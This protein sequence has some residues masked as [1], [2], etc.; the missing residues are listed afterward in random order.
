MTTQSEALEQILAIARHHQ[1]TPEDISAAFARHETPAQNQTSLLSRVFSL[2]G[3]TFLFAGLSVFIALN[4][5]VMNTW[6][7]IIITL[8]SGLAVFILALIA[9][10]DRLYAQA[11]TPLYIIAAILQPTGILVTL[12][13]LSDGGDWHAAVLIM[14]GAMVLQQ[15]ITFAQKQDTTLLFTTLLFACWFAGTLFDLLY[16]D[17]D[18]ILLIIG[19]SVCALCM[20]LAKIPGQ[21]HRGMTPFWFLCASTSIYVG[22]FALVEDTLLEWLFLF[23][24][25]GGVFLSTVIPSRM[26][27]VSSTVAILAYVGYFTSEYLLDAVGWPLLLMVMG[28]VMIGLGAM[29]VRIN[30][31]Y[32]SQ[33]SARNRH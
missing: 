29:A 16:M 28:L 15:G 32:I 8:G 13:E 22:L 19:L 4:W 23:A 18:L 31:R 26:V 10:R 30:Q 11:R 25:C 24:T 7:R 3:A 5:E 21:P 9:A 17:V 14:S 33:V 1:L 2:L 27:L 20:G 6:A 12:D